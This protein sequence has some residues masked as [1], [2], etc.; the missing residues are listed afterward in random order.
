LGAKTVMFKSI[1]PKLWSTALASFF[2]GMVVY[3]AAAP[4]AIDFDAR[5]ILAI[6]DASDIRILH[7]RYYEYKYPDR[8]ADVVYAVRREAFLPRDSRVAILAAVPRNPIEFWA[9]YHFAEHPLIASKRPELGAVFDKYLL[10][11]AGV[12]SKKSTTTDQMKRYLLLTVFSDGDSAE[13][14]ADLNA[15]VA[16]TNPDTFTRAIKLL[17]PE[18]RRRICGSPLP[19]GQPEE[20]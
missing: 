5:A 7:K 17:R 8:V 18:E 3:G 6:S 9:V 15:Q 13:V 1:K 2:F 14:L 20:P 10:L 11:L 16:R 4:C 19:C 12:V